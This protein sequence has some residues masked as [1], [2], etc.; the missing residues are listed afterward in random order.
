MAL[1]NKD[2]EGQETV[3]VET[4]ETTEL[5]SE[6]QGSGEESSNTP[7]SKR[8][9]APAGP[10][11]VWTEGM[12]AGLAEVLKAPK[13]PGSIRTA[14]SVAEMLNTLP[15]FAEENQVTPQHVTSFV[16]S[17]VAQIETAIKNGERTVPVPEWLTLDKARRTNINL[18]L[19]E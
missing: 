10:R 7:S 18:S 15:A 5:A 12:Q 8:R 16:T 2:K 3:K 6:A 19:F 4:A 14:I 11:K 1:K 17:S 13:S 9:G